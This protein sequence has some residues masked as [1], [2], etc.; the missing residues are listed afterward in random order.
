M[1]VR[2]VR[3]GGALLSLSF[4]VVLLREIRESPNHTFMPSERFT[5]LVIPL[6]SATSGT[7]YKPLFKLASR[8]FYGGRLLYT[9]TG[10]STFQVQRLLISGDVSPNPGPKRKSTTKYPCG[11]C[12]KPVRRN[13]NAILCA[14]CNI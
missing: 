8:R 13:Q 2:R 12:S 3:M 10:V 14:E 9:A 1:A 5:R 11:E 6:H 4:L 7:Y